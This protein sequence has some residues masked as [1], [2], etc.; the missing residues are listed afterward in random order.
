MKENRVQYYFDIVLNTMDDVLVLR[1]VPIMNLN[2]HDNHFDTVIRI[3]DHWFVLN[4]NWESS[5][6]LD[7]DV[8]NKTFTEYDDL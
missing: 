6:N 5:L 2:L 1:N 3:N 8:Y 4:V 7:T